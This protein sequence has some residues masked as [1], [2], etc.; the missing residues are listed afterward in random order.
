MTAFQGN[1]CLNGSF[2]PSQVDTIVKAAQKAMHSKALSDA[3]AEH[4]LVVAEASEARKAYLQQVLDSLQYLREHGVASTAK[5]AVGAIL[6]RVDEAQRLPV[7]R[8]SEAL[9]LVRGVQDAWSRLANLPPGLY[10]SIH[11]E[12]GLKIVVSKK[13]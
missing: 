11:R 2:G 4:D 7:E 12:Q 13:Y 6:T 3:R 8:E 1:S 9:P 10:L 5:T